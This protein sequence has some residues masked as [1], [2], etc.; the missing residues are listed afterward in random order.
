[1]KNKI[2]EVANEML[3]LLSNDAEMHE[4]KLSLDS[5][6]S[7]C[8]MLTWEN[9]SESEKWKTSGYAEDYETLENVKP[10]CVLAILEIDN[11]IC[12]YTL[13]PEEKYYKQVVMEFESE[14]TFPLNDYQDFKK[15]L[16]TSIWEME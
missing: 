3:A 8:L 10:M 6:D 1:M 9:P 15:A 16:L 12:A 14:Q 13:T 7:E 2:Q 11:K 4:Y 5:K